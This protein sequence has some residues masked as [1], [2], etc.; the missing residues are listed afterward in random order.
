MLLLLILLLSALS[1]AGLCAIG[2]GF[3]GFGWL[4]QFPVGFAGGFLLSAVLAFG[5]LVG[6][7]YLID[8]EK[9]RE[10]DSRWF[11]TMVMWYIQAILTVLPIRIQKQG[12]EKF[13]VDG[14]FVLVCRKL[15]EGEKEE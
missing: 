6:I 4:W 11:R 14:R 10:K 8:P 1:G 5:I 15:R 7:C 13:Q 3:E 12:M 2:G 9:P